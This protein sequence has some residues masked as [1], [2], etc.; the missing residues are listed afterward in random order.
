MLQVKDPVRV[1]GRPLGRLLSKPH[2]FCGRSRSSTQSSFSHPIV[3]LQPSEEG[4]YFGE[5][6]SPHLSA[7]GEKWRIFMKTGF[8]CLRLARLH[9]LMAWAIFPAPAIYTIVL[10]HSSKSIHLHAIEKVIGCLRLS[11]VSFLCVMSYRAAG[12]AWDDLIDRDFDAQVR[13]SMKRPLPSG[14][15]SVD[16]ALLYIILQTGL[17]FIL[18]QVLAA[19]EVF[20]SFVLSGALFGIYPYLKRWT[21]YTQLFGSLLITMGVLQGWLFCATTYEPIYGIAPGWLHA[22]AILRRDWLQILPIFLMEFVYELAHEL[23]YGCQDTEEDIT[24]GLHSLSILC[25][26]EKSRRLSTTLASCF[27]F[28]LAVCSKNAKVLAWPA[29]LIPPVLLVRWTHKLDLS[30]S[31]CCAQWAVAAIKV[32]ILVTFSLLTLFVL[33]EMDILLLM[34][35]GCL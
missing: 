24:I 28:L 2:T 26:Y 30:V 20:L 17:T 34:G 6:C 1:I 18:L 29:L 10:Y 7:S 35:M 27:C 31:S 5:D 21:H 25:G 4:K 14:D 32:K 9:T 12:L 8:A 11:V 22:A 19:Q 3:L 23:V 15:I 16:G 13:R 33:K